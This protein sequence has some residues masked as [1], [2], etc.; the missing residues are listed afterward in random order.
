M[1]AAQGQDEG[2]AQTGPLGA[3]TN[4][5]LRPREINRY[6]LDLECLKEL[7]AFD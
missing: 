2:A 3:V 5:L 4:D 7:N 1:L 6:R